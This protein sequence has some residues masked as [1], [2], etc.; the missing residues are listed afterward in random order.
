MSTARDDDEDD[1][2]GGRTPTAMVVS[3]VYDGSV[4]GPDTF[5][6]PVF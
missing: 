6:T 5:V 4:I 1:C 3:R 2:H